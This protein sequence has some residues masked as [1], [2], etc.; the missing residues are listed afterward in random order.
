M[1]FKTQLISSTFAGRHGTTTDQDVCR[2]SFNIFRVMV[3][4]HGRKAPIRLVEKIS[5]L[6]ATHAEQ[7]A[8]LSDMAREQ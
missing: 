2:N 7:L 5:R 8:A 1:V 3:R 6:E 4:L